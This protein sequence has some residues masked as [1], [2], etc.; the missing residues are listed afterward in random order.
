MND[1]SRITPD[2]YPPIAMLMPHREPMVLLDRVVA[3][4]PGYVECAM[5]VREGARFVEAGRLAAPYT[6]EHMAQSVAVCL[7]YEAYRGGRGVRV[8][9]IVSCRVFEAHRSAASVG[10]ELI[11]HATRDRGN[12][13]LSHFQ[14]EVR[15]QGE[16]LASSTL[17]LF[18]GETLFEDEL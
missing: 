12:E 2:D 6:I 4:S 15:S 7:G 14:C 18:H 3:W 17:T 16:V 9:M 13:T 8:G 5:R 11:V 10:E 1:P